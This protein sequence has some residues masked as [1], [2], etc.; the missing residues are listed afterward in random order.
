MSIAID[1]FHGGKC[2][3]TD[4][5]FWC[6]VTWTPWM[7]LICLSMS[8]H[9]SVWSMILTPISCWGA[10]FYLPMYSLVGM[11]IEGVKIFTWHDLETLQLSVKTA[12]SDFIP[13]TQYRMYIYVHISGAHLVYIFR[14][15]VQFATFGPWNN[16]MWPKEAW[17]EKKEQWTETDDYKSDF[18]F[19]TI[20][21]TC[22]L[23]WN[24]KSP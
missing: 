13:L 5:I 15:L 7:P 22:T 21:V 23:W 2:E 10:K 4:A 6:I 16:L 19:D 14:C 18:I 1:A 3:V 12:L 9:Q 11:S 8:G 20:P 24:F 17:S